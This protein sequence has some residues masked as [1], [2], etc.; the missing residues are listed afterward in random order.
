MLGPS[1]ILRCV[2]AFVAYPYVDS[3][4]LSRNEGS[5]CARLERATVFDSSS[6]CMFPGCCWP[7]AEGRGEGSSS[8][9]D[10]LSCLLFTLVGR[11]GVS[12]VV[13]CF[14][15]FAV[16]AFLYGLACLPSSTVVGA[17]ASTSHRSRNLVRLLTPIPSL[18]TWKA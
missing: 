1:R 15:L 6:S 18:K 10:L 5:D 17:Q 16:L 12:V 2:Q 13:V 14:C 11:R 8:G 7:S 4:R 9:T 3:W